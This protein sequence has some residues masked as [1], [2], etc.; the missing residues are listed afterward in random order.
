MWG[1]VSCIM[2]EARCS[3]KVNKGKG[4]GYTE[5]YERIDTDKEEIKLFLAWSTAGQ[6][7]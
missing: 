7:D 1:F 6:G 4:K 3:K 5:L 2:N